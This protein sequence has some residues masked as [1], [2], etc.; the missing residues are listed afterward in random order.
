VHLVAQRM[1][2]F[3][4]H[5]SS[6]GKREGEFPLLHGWGDQVKHGGA[7][8]PRD[9]PKRAVQARDIYIPYLHID[10][11]KVKARNFH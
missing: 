6:L 11:L 2:D 8:D 5:L 9:N 1:F 4:S 10:T 3:S 7:P